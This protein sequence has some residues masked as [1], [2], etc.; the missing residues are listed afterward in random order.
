MLNTEN[1][2]LASFNWSA[3]TALNKVATLGV[4]KLYLLCYIV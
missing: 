2:Y 1:Q 4:N 3:M